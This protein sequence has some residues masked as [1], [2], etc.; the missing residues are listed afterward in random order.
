MP[1]LSD[2]DL[3]DAVLAL[4]LDAVDS[5]FFDDIKSVTIG[6]FTSSIDAHHLDASVCVLH[7][8]I[9]FE[10]WS[11]LDERA[12]DCED[13][14][15]G[16]HFDHWLIIISTL[17][18]PRR[19]FPRWDYNISSLFACIELFERVR[20]IIPEEHIEKA[21]YRKADLGIENAQVWILYG[22]TFLES[23][24]LCLRCVVRLL[25]DLFGGSYGLICWSISRILWLNVRA[26][27]LLSLL[28][29]LIITTLLND[30]NRRL[31]TSLRMSFLLLLNEHLISSMGLCSSNIFR[32]VFFSCLILWVIN[33]ANNSYLWLLITLF[34]LSFL[35]FRLSKVWWCGN[36]LVLRYCFD[37]VVKTLWMIV[38]CRLGRFH[39]I[40][41]RDV[42]SSYLSHLLHICRHIINTLSFWLSIT[43][44]CSCASHWLIIIRIIWGSARAS[45]HRWI[46]IWGVLSG[47]I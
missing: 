33:L 28:N 6:D 14:F 41:L 30:L 42:L 44:I 36:L 11:L 21:L 25:L 35:R 27:W 23:I 8:P 46:L 26:P 20:G 17:I 40:F 4:R 43:I 18:R 10:R 7:H 31:M 45:L 47:L 3:N 29:R 5:P 9:R 12:I 32:S 19:F 16:S 1:Y 24:K 22:H 38:L 13:G 37:L 39:F 2:T 15:D 34:L